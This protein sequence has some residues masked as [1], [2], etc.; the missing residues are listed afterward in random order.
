MS[1]LIQYQT[2]QELL[3]K[4]VLEFI[5]SKDCFLEKIFPAATIA[6]FKD[7]LSVQTQE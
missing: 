1:Y 5:Q 6:E 2:Q 4:E 3:A 7:H